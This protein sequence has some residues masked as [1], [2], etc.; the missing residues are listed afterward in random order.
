MDGSGTLF[1]D[2]AAALER[3]RPQLRLLV[4]PY[5]PERP[6]SYAELEALVVE[7]LPI[8]QTYA[9]LG[10]SFSG[11][12]AMAIAARRPAGLCELI[13]CCTFARTPVR[14]LRPF[15]FLLKWLPLRRLPDWLPRRLL[16]ER[17]SSKELEH[18]LHQA[19]AP[20]A[21]A[22]LGARLAAVLRVDYRAQLARV[23]VPTLYLRAARDRLIAHDVAPQLRQILPDLEIADFATPHLL[24]QSAPHQA[25]ARVAG[26]LDAI[27]VAAP[28]HG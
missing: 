2:F 7:R 10:E 24:L 26:F 4:M 23:R 3:L 16:L 1:E 22:T 15:A 21:A 19:L 8:D 9:V 14:W 27:N 17:G 18:S 20:L 11:P 6:L 13:L 25:A 28:A 5:P 12:I